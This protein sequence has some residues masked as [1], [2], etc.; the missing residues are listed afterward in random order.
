MRER[1]IIFRGTAF[2]EVGL[3]EDSLGTVFSWDYL[4]WEYFT[5]VAYFRRG[6]GRKGV[7][8]QFCRVDFSGR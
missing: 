5:R 4:H 7:G 8:G 2:D 3:S 6:T 1:R